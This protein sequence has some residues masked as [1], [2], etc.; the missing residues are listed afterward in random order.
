M[1]VEGRGTQDEPNRPWSPGL[2]DICSPRP[3]SGTGMAGLAARRFENR[4]LEMELLNS[5]HES[6]SHATT[7]RYTDL[8]KCVR[9]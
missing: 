3:G 8:V 2:S 4:S 7:E 6:S 9:G 1:S 5:A